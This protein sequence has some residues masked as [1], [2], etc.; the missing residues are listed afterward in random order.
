MK[1]ILFTLLCALF[2]LTSGAQCMV[3]EIPLQ[4]RAISSN[5]IVEGEVIARN[6]YWN[7]IHNMIYTSNTIEVYKIFRGAEMPSQIEIIT[8]GGTVD[9]YRIIAEPELELNVGDIGV[10]TCI[11]VT[12]AKGLPPSRSAISQYEAYASVQGFVKYNVETQTASDPFRTYQDIENEIYNVVLS[13]SFE[14]YKTVKEYS[15]H[16]IEGNGNEQ[17]GGPSISGFSPSLLRGG[18]G[19]VLTINGNGFGSSQGSGTVGF[20]NADDG[21]SSYISPIASQ[22]LT[23]SDTQITVQVPENAGTGT[24]RVSQGSTTTSVS[25]LTV[26]YTHLNIPYGGSSLQTDHVNS[27]G[28]GGYTWHMNT[29][30]DA[31]AAAKACFMRAFDTWRC[32]TGIEWV[33][34]STT[35]IN[36]AVADGTNVICFDNTNPLPAGILGICWANWSGCGT[37][38][39]IW[40]VDELDIIFDEG[41]NISP[42][43]W[44]F[45]PAT[46]NMNQ[47]DFESVGVHELGHGHLLGHVIDNG[48]IMHYALTNGAT[49]RSLGI[50]DQ[51]GGDFVQ[52]KSEIANSCGPGAMSHHICPI[53]PVASF[54]SSQNTICAGE[55]VDF[56]DNSSGGPTSWTWT[57]PSGSPGSATTQNVSNVLWSTAGTYTVSLTISNANGS[58]TYTQTITVNTAPATPTIFVIGNV[59]VC[60][61]TGSS[62][63]WYLNGNPIPGA[64]GQSHNPVQS[65]SYTVVVFDSA[66][67]GS[68]QSAPVMVTGV[69]SAGNTVSF[70]SVFPNPANGSFQLTFTATNDNYTL[71][72]H[73]ML[74]QIVYSEAL[75]GFSGTYNKTFDMAAYGQGVYF[76]R[77]RGNENEST[78]RVVIY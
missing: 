55:T 24:I 17:L 62:Y 59:L 1:R 34:G 11:P 78:V 9:L 40:Y 10:F 61:A 47:Y 5:L 66:G 52:A 43:T 18:T 28:A 12:R 8:E 63:Q 21:G 22:Y 69:D 54:T 45:G 29:G 50:N 16:S 25:A 60:S 51:D 42:D 57:F 56:T 2:Y 4:Q 26:S 65:G 32:G 44:Q 41:S 35:S 76:I 19:D 13:P 36:D 53:P 39:Y 49:N 6:S 68:A 30:F 37:A 74:G 58:S 33:I 73:D 67:C 77:L 75:P 31:N 38:P 3:R 72:I 46:P 70:I 14:N 20:K 15:F 71:E 7:T 23:W 64:T 48:T 27:N